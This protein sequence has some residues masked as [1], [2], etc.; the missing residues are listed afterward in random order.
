MEIKGPYK[1]GFPTDRGRG[2]EERDASIKGLVQFA[3]WMAVVLAVTLV[4]MKWTFDYFKRTEPMGP[5]A[6][7]LVTESQRVLPPSPRLQSQPH[8]ELADYCLAQQQEV[9]TYSWVD[10][11]SGVV[12]IPVD[13]A[14]DLI[15]ERG[16]PARPSSEAPSGAASAPVATPITAGGN[17]L[18]GPCGYLTEHP[19]ETAPMGIN[20]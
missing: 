1:P 11:G 5:T 17:D 15:L 6:S 18:L 4:G 13:R 14:M 3:I 16:L 10:Q 7:P 2:F 20:E 19:V 12:H 9:T 8:R